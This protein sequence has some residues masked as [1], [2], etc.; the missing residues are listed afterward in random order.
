MKFSTGAFV[1]LFVAECAAESYFGSFF[2]SS[3]TPA[4]ST[5][6]L[7]LCEELEVVLAYGRSLF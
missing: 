3:A 7:H 5:L 4:V 2:K 6:V 1:A